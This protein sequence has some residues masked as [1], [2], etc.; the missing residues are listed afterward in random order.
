MSTLRT[1]WRAQPDAHQ[2]LRM[3]RFRLSTTASAGVLLALVTA[4]LG[5]AIASRP[6]W[7]AASLVVTVNLL[8]FLLF[9]LGINLRARDPSL[10]IYQMLAASATFRLCAA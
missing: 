2:A 8:F 10:T 7:A 3:R 1:L 5:G 6:F 9:R 4:H